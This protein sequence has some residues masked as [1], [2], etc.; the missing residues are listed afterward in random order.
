MINS[1]TDPAAVPKENSSVRNY[2]MLLGVALLL[3]EQYPTRMT[4]FRRRESSFCFLRSPSGFSPAQC[5][6]A[7]LYILPS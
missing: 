3:T 7:P 1:A 2:R 4:L 5:R 6:A